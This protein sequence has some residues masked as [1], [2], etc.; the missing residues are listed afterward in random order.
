[1]KKLLFCGAAAAIL[2]G[3]SA[4]EETVPVI[5]AQ[6]EKLATFE[7]GDMI[8]KCP[9]AEGL[10]AMQAQQVSGKFIQGGDLPL[11]E[12]AADAEHVYVNVVPLKSEDG[13]DIGTEYRIMAKNAD[14]NADAWAVIISIQ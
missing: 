9:L 11:A 4:R 1:M 8:V 14:L 10:V 3:C 6:C 5:D 2:A 7:A 12:F 13:K